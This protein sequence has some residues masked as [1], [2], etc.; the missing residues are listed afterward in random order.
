MCNHLHRSGLS[1]LS[2]WRHKDRPWAHESH[3][4]Q[5][6][7]S[8]SHTSW[9]LTA[10]VHKSEDFNDIKYSS[11]LPISISIPGGIFMYTGTYN[12]SYGNSS[13]K[14][15][16]WFYKPASWE[17]INRN[18]KLTQ[19]TTGAYISQYLMPH[20]CCHPC[21]HNLA[22]SF[23]S[24]LSG[25]RFL[26]KDQISMIGLITRGIWDLG[27]ISQ[28]LRFVWY[29]ISLVIASTNWF[30]SSCCS[31]SLNVYDSLASLE[32]EKTWWSILLHVVSKF[33]FTSWNWCAADCAVVSADFIVDFG[34]VSIAPNQNNVVSTDRLNV[35]LCA[36]ILGD[37]L[38]PDS[39]SFIL[40]DMPNVSPPLETLLVAGM[41]LSMTLSR[42]TYG[43]SA[44]TVSPS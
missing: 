33:S 23:F 1:C 31:I 39:C 11:L 34:L 2:S 32:T 40:S 29:P 35:A 18:L 22:L 20:C 12:F 38:S 24:F 44:D 43:S 15:S 17:I 16:A 9:R 30:R 37:L 13:T 7:S 3:G 28:C 25:Y 26:L 4:A 6:P 27:T 14:S 21:A 8:V 42:V 19:F 5:A 41:T 10:W 36:S